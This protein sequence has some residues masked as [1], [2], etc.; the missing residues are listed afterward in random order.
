MSVVYLV[1]ADVPLEGVERFQRYEAE[2]IPL[3]LE[4]R[5]QLERRLRSAD[6]RIETHIVRFPSEAHFASYVGDPRRADHQ[7]LL[8]DSGAQLALHRLFDV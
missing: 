3:L 5:G 2:V 1:F 6:G 4:H 8:R 7:Q